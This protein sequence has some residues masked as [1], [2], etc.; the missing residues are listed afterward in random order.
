MSKAINLILDD[1][2]ILELLRIQMDDDAEAALAWLKAHF[3]GT[4]R[5]LLEDLS[6][7]DNRRP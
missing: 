7:P 5:E 1:E 2:D 4:G 3:R 6:K